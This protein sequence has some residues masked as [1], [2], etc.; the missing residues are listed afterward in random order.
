MVSSRARSEDR[1]TV[2]IASAGQES[3]TELAVLSAV[4]HSSV[5]LDFVIG[6]SSGSEPELLRRLVQRGNVRIEVA[7]GRSHA[8]WLDAWVR[9]SRSKYAIFVDSDVFFRR[10]CWVSPLLEELTAGT[11]LVTCHLLGREE[12]VVEPVRGVVTTAMPRPAP[13]VMAID[14]PRVREVGVSFAY[15]DTVQDGQILAWDIGGRMLEAL[16]ASGLVARSLPDSYHRH[17]T[18]IGGM[19]WRAR[20][21]ARSETLRWLHLHE[22][23]IRLLRER[24]Y[25]LMHV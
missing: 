11:A 13:W 7:R 25:I 22:A 2:Y 9:A 10:S 6:G 12:A 20:P 1:V 14:V 16:T 5:P 24:L 4:R 19:S 3:L 18:H 17:Y 21:N 15:M 23:Q 8:E